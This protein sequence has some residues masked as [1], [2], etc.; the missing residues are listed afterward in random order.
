MKELLK[1]NKECW[2]S[3]LTQFN[4]VADK[5]LAIHVTADNTIRGFHEYRI[6]VRPQFGNNVIGPACIYY[7]KDTDAQ[8]AKNFTSALVE[9][10]QR[11][12]QSQENYDALIS[13]FYN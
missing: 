4:S 8:R 2:N 6:V 13:T 10:L 12:T 11:G 7:H 9:Q 1:R 3:F 5:D